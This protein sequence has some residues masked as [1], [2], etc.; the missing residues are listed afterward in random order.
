M[1]AAREGQ[2]RLRRAS[3]ARWATDSAI[4]GNMDLVPDT[5]KPL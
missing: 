5:A 2:V 3:L 1:S 4:P